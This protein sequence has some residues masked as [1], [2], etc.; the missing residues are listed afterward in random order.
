MN[1][2]ILYKEYTL[3][4]PAFV[5]SNLHMNVFHNIDLKF[6]VFGGQQKTF[7]DFKIFDVTVNI[8]GGRGFISSFV[9]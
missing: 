1:V 4:F 8:F 7:E 3:H 2:R 5:H 6:S 9:L